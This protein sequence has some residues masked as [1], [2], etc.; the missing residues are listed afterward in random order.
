MACLGA[1][2]GRHI[3]SPPC[4]RGTASAAA[5][6]LQVSALVRSASRQT[7]DSRSEQL[8]VKNDCLH[9]VIETSQSSPMTK[10]RAIQPAHATVGSSSNTAVTTARN[11]VFNGVE[12]LAATCVMVV[13][14]GHGA[15]GPPACQSRVLAI[16]VGEPPVLGVLHGLV[17]DALGH[18]VEQGHASGLV[19]PVAQHLARPVLVVLQPLAA[20]PAI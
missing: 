9:V 2:A 12:T 14:E 7:A 8:V 5:C 16:R 6:F 10:E 1:S 3:Q 15:I 19:Q 4:L 11:T 13:D 20:P 18:K 17:Q